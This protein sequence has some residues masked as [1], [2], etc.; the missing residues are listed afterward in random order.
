M[1]AGLHAD[2]QEYFDS[3]SE[4]DQDRIF[5]KAGAQAIR[6]GADVSR[7]VSARRGAAG[8]GYAGHSPGPHPPG[9][10]RGRFVK[11]TIGYRPNGA[12][13]QVYTTSEGTTVRGSFGRANRDLSETRRADGARYSSTGRVRLMPESI[14]E[15]AGDDLELRQA[16]LR[17]AGYLDYVPRGG[18]AAYARQPLGGGALADIAEQR[19]ADR[20]LVDRAT[21]R[22][23]N[24]YLG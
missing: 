13:V 21:A 14:V 3:L 1:P 20:I 4:A 10:P 9:V 2:P 7:V 12:P 24:F 15:I 5:T 22:Y 17:D 11:T 23:A 18:W 16:F 6:D 19:R 8:I